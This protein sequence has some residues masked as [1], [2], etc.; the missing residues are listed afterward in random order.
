MC[1]ERWEPINPFAPAIPVVIEYKRLYR[2]LL[3]ETMRLAKLNPVL[4]GCG[5]YL[6]TGTCSQ[7]FL[8][9]DRHVYER[10]V[11]GMYRR[12]GQR[13]TRPGS[14]DSQAVSRPWVSIAYAARSATRRKPHS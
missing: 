14:L 9:M 6:R 10:L 8:K 4:R 3:P 11:R 2:V 12:G 13:C 5:N 7:E 1:A